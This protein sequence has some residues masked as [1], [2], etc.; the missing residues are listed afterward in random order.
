MF[1]LEG[2]ANLH[3]RAQNSV[4]D[5]L[6]RA[7]ASQ[8]YRLHFVASDNARVSVVLSWHGARSSD[9]LKRS[10]RRVLSRRLDREFKRRDWFSRRLSYRR[11]KDRK[12]FDHLVKAQLLG[13]DGWKWSEGRG[14]FNAVLA[15]VPHIGSTLRGHALAHS[16]E[17]VR[18]R[19]WRIASTT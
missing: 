15:A 19:G 16:S 14:Y 10:I 11:V 6:I 1:T 9:A 13:R 4:I 18:A 2:A 17:M 7:A 12:D 8:E 5:E 3:A